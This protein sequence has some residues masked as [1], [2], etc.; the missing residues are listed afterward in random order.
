MKTL[1]ILLGVYL[2]LDFVHSIYYY[3]KIKEIEKK[4]KN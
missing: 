3:K 4:F 2:I 1:I